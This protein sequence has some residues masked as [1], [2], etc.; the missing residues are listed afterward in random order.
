MTNTALF[1]Q[2]IAE[3]APEAH[4]F[5]KEAA[6]EIWDSP[7]EPEI[8]ADVMGIFAKGESFLKQAGFGTEFGLGVAGALGA[9][10]ATGLAGD[11]MDAIKRGLSKTRDYRG[12]LRE[13]PDLQGHP[14]G[15]KAVQGVFGTLHKFNPEFASDPLVAGT[16][17]RNHLESAD[18]HRIDIGMLSSMTTARKNIQDVKSKSVTAP[19]G[20]FGAGKAHQ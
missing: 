16:F 8:T 7:F 5:I 11:A 1:F 10:I 14:M 6:P 13:N 17:V 15:A 3:V 2:K 19:S 20:A 9:G 18:P 12:M 4:Q